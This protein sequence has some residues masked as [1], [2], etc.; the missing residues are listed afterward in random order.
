MTEASSPC[1]TPP[2]FAGL[3]AVAR[4]DI[5]PPVG[6][7]ARLWGAAKHDQAKGIHR[8]MTLTAVAIAS[9]DNPSSPALLISMDLSHV[10]NASD[11]VELRTAVCEATGVGED[12][13]AIACTHTHSSPWIGRDREN[14]PGGDKLPAYRE[15]I[16]TRMIEAAAEAVESLAPATITFATGRATLA[17]NRD[18]RDPDPN[19]DRFVTGYNPSGEPDDTLLVGRITRDSDN[20]V[21]GTIVNYACHPTTL[22]WENTQISPDYV[23]AM[24]ELVED[25]TG[26]APCAF[27]QG[28][29]GEL[30]PAYQYV[31]EVAVADQGGRSLGY[32]VLS[33]LELMLPPKQRL[34]FQGVM[35]SGAPLAVWRPETFEPSTAFAATRI[36]AELPLK[37]L[38]SPDEIQQQLD[39]TEDRAMAERLRRKM[40]MLKNL[41]GGPTATSPIMVWRLGDIAFVGQRTESYSRFQQTLRNAFPERAVLAA[42]LVNGALGYLYPQELGPL[43]VYQVWQ[44]PFAPEA[45]STLEKA[46]ENQIRKLFEA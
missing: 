15:L 5:T 30:S 25:A 6:I 23:G 39:E 41:G 44:S 1:D 29:S 33:T 28:A 22:A 9:R 21:I 24:R 4:R 38:P 8:R 43:N 46:C 16:R 3:V 14:M 26:G 7:Y 31:G 13:L 45:L 40:Q 19:A 34:R 36:N 17:T 2:S 11:D 35:E 12:A 42:G 18:L 27:L 32:A 20:G 37:P 10:H